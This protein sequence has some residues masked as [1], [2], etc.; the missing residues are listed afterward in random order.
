MSDHD[1]KD[2]KA[3]TVPVPVGLEALLGL[4]AVDEDFRRRLVERRGDLADAAGVELT[5]S[6]RAILASIPSEQLEAM[7]ERVPPPPSH[8]RE[9][10]RSAAASAVVLL[11]GASLAGCE[12]VRPPQ[13]SPVEGI[14]AE[15][16][17]PMTAGVMPD[18]PPERP[19]P[20][21]DGGATG[22]AAAATDGATPEAGAAAG[23]DGAP[24]PGPSA[25]VE[26]RP[27]PEAPEPQVPRPPEVPTRPVQPAAT[28]GIRPDRPTRPA[29]SR[30]I[31]PDRPM[32]D[33]ERPTFG[34]MPDDP[35]RKS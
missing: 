13:E 34:A 18:M 28:R 9:F 23:G 21:R 14:R 7:A 4:A 5:P 8:R 16:P 30:G 31:R 25:A 22:D 20:A 12:R 35:S 29:A 11:G 27:A 32:R 6:E 17:L 33:P 3:S 26:T 15:E 19:V 1:G 2:L 10:L 24:A